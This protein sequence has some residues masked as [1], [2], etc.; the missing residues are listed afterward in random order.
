MS[1]CLSV[2]LYV[3]LFVSKQQGKQPRR[4]WVSTV[5]KKAGDIQ[6]MPVTVQMLRQ[7]WQIVH[8]KCELSVHLYTILFTAS[9]IDAHEHE[10]YTENFIIIIIITKFIECTNSSKLESEALILHVVRVRLSCRHL[11]GKCLHF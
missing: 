11:F 8:H 5:S 7:I 6:L 1:V 3:S 10:N 4:Q 2:Y 9:Y